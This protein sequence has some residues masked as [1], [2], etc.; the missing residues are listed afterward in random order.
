VDLARHRALRQV[1]LGSG[2]RDAAV[3]RRGFKGQQAGDGGQ[4]VA[5]QHVMSSR[6]EAGPTITQTTR[7]LSWT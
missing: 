7:G 1:Q 2:A 6:H 3:A 4:Q 5:A